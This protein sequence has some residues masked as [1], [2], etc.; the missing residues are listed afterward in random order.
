MI[1]NVVRLENKIGERVYHFI[2]D[3][4]SPIQDIKDSLFQFGKYIGQVEDAVKAQQEKA[5]A[6]QEAK[7]EPKPAE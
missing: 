4:D 5:K 7:E 6:E 2:C 1:K 3:N